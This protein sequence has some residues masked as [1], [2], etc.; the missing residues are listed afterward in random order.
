MKD[1]V[2]TPHVN[3][4]LENLSELLFC[5]SPVDDELAMRQSAPL[6]KL[7]TTRCFPELQT[8]Q[9]NGVASEPV[10]YGRCEYRAQPKLDTTLLPMASPDR[11]RSD[12]GDWTEHRNLAKRPIPLA[13]MAERQHPQKSGGRGAQFF[14]NRP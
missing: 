5:S 3:N 7:V 14:P 4:V 12:C 13:T 6:G 10:L 2:R 8:S 1:N 11:L 9:I